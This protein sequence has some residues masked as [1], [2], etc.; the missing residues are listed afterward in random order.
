[1]EV[2]LN[3]GKYI[4]AVS[5]GVDSVVL[6]DLLLNSKHQDLDTEFIVAHFD[7][8]IREDSKADAD[9]VKNLATKHKLVFELGQGNLGAD[10]S[11]ALA[12]EKRY[13]FLKSV[14]SKHK[15]TAIITAHHQDDLIETSIINLLRGTGRRGLTS[16][17]SDSQI[18]RPLLKFSKIELI[19]YAKDHKLNWHEDITNTD[20]KYLRNY[21]RTKVVAKMTSQQRDK[22]LV[23]LA[24]LEV[25][26]GKIDYEI[27][28]ILGLGLHKNQLVLNRKWFIMLPHDVSKEIILAILS[29]SKV[30]EIDR[31]T[32]ERLA[33][34][35]KT[36]QGGKIA[37]AAGVDIY[38][39]KR[40]ARFK[41]R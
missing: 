37:Q 20:L 41:I 11:E 30:A 5:G 2:S 7:H 17:K 35:I 32:V 28:K 18:T 33:V 39:T 22:W 25:I 12:R 8:G 9:F 31:K 29:K 40:S 13:E 16:L 24:K 15:A 21:V 27:Q 1:M 36:L 6:L 19:K 10:A 26:N 23:I 4:M 34:Q 38:L 14:Q 3:K